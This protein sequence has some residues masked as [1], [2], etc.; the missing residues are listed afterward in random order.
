MKAEIVLDK[1]KDLCFR[2]EDDSI[3]SK[4]F[5]REIEKSLYES[6]LHKN[7][8]QITMT[9]QSL[10]MG[11]TTFI[12]RLKNIAKDLPHDVRALYFKERTR[13]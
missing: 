7:K 12:M 3:N 2:I 13:K 10:E 8:G 1:I 6:F 4:K 11:R 5:L 9:S